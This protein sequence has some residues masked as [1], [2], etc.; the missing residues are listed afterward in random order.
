MRGEITYH[1]EC[2]R[3]CDAPEER[4]WIVVGVEDTYLSVEVGG[5]RRWTLIQGKVAAKF[6]WDHE[7]AGS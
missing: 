7:L 2:R 3:G 4:M 1:F 6:R 5:R